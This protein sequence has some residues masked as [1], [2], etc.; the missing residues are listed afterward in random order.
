M[1]KEKKTKIFIFIIIAGFISSVFYHYILANYLHKGMPINTFLFLSNDQFMDFVNVYKAKS[2]VYFPFGNLIINFFCLIKPL[3]LSLLL[4]Q[5]ISISSVFYYFFKSLQGKFDIDSFTNSI[6]FCLF[7]FP[8]LFLI[9]RANFESFVFVFMG[10]FIYLYQ[11][12]EVNYSIIPLSLAISMKLFPIVFLVLLFSDR[13]Y[14]QIIWTIILVVIATLASSLIL[15]GSFSNYILQFSHDADFYQKAYVIGDKGLDFGHSLF[16][17]IKCAV[18]KINPGFDISILLKPYAILVLI[19]FLFIS[20]YVVLIERS[21]WKKAALLVFSMC[22]F[23]YV[24]ANYKLIY[25]FIPIFIFINE[26]NPDNQ[27]YR[28]I[29]KKFTY[30]SITID[31]IYIALFGLLVIPKNYRLFVDLYDGVYID[32]LLMLAC[33]FL[34]LFMGLNKIKSHKNEISNKIRFLLFRDK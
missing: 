9:D 31:Y 15:N 26:N 4:F 11:K 19:L 8:V 22:L 12:G 14:I 28:L 6:I 17:L 18:L 3:N 32:P 1:T 5:F 21:L 16:G 29:F 10:M 30:K 2:S 23:P 13:R 24:S 20:L 33:S 34:I 25:L 7:S 27:S